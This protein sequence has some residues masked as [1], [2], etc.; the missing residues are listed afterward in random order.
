MISACWHCQGL[1]EVPDDATSAVVFCSQACRE[2]HAASWRGFSFEWL[3]SRPGALDP[4]GIKKDLP[5][6]K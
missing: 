2:A 4:G 5:G 6:S 3:R 1:F